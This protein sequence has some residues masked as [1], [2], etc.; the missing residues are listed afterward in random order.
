MVFYHKL[1]LPNFWAKEKPKSALI[2]FLAKLFGRHYF[3]FKV[4]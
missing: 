1:K 2:E 4:E 3:A